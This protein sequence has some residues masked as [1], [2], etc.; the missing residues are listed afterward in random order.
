MSKD[1]LSQDEVDSLLRGV[2]GEAEE[3]D[4]PE[5][6]EGDEAER[7]ADGRHVL[8][9]E[10]AAEIAA[11]DRAETPQHGSAER[12][13]DRRQPVRGERA[14]RGV[15]GGCSA[16]TSGG[17]CEGPG[18]VAPAPARPPPTARSCATT[19]SSTPWAR[20]SAR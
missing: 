3:N 8:E 18:G 10:P 19:T 20:A 16:G 2:T 13:P 11:E 4:K 12:L 7:E 17:T 6:A 5:E 9:G 15:L 1:F 14:G